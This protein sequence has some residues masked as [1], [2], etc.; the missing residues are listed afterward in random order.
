MELLLPKLKADLQLSIF[1]LL[2][3]QRNNLL[4]AC[5]VCCCHLIIAQK[6]Q[7]GFW[8][9]AS[10]IDNPARNTWQT[11]ALKIVAAASFL[12]ESLTLQCVAL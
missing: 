1:Q 8:N 12:T 3:S 9:W 7:Y 10:G 2:S 4:L 5:E 6:L 11:E